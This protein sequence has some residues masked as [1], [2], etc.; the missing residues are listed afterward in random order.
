MRDISYTFYRPSEDNLFPLIHVALTFYTISSIHNSDI[1]FY[2]WWNWI[3]ILKIWALKPSVVEIHRRVIAGGGMAS[4]L[5]FSP[6]HRLLIL[7]FSIL[8]VG[9]FFSLSVLFSRVMDGMEWSGVE[10]WMM[11]YNTAHHLS[12]SLWSS[13]E[14]LA[15]ECVCYFS[16][17]TRVTVEESLSVLVLFLFDIR[18]QAM[19]CKR[20]RKD[21]YRGVWVGGTLFS[22]LKLEVRWA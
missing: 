2:D 5:L 18:G 3:E 1:H 22:W 4:L 16:H 13:F 9:F 10:Q 14:S 11:I 7:F 19:R 15:L 8:P 21:I 6:W 17:F 12:E 20:E